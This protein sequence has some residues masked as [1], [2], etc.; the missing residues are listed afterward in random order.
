M[1]GT[2]RDKA[3]RL[4]AKGTSKSEV[5]RRCNVSRKTVQRWSQEPDFI[6][7]IE[8]GVEE[9]LIESADTQVMLATTLSDITTK[10]HDLLAYR[11]TQ[12]S[13]AEGMEDLATKMLPVCNSL[14]ERLEREPEQVTIR[15][16]PQLI[17]AIGELTKVSSDC[18]A[19]ATGIEPRIREE[20]QIESTARETGAYLLNEAEG[21]QPLQELVKQAYPVIHGRRP[22]TA[23]ESLVEDLDL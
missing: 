14:V 15:M 22:R 12:R 6:E 13:L 16:L 5:A 23:I 3:K 10:I 8:N 21:H 20:L 9:E 2:L 4:L 19:R 1:S 7:A 17:K 18:Y 11:D